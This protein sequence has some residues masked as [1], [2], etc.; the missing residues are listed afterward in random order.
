MVIFRGS[1]TYFTLVN[2]EFMSHDHRLVLV[3]AIEQGVVL[4]PRESSWNTDVSQLHCD[5]AVRR[6][7]PVNCTVIRSCAG[8]KKK[9]LKLSPITGENIKKTNVDTNEK[10]E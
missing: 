1:L 5:R 4:V 2:V 3:R 6:L 8:G 10:N 7:C 9:K